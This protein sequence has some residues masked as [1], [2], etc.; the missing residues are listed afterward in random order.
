MMLDVAVTSWIADR[1]QATKEKGDKLNCIKIKH[2]CAS[3]DTLK[4]V[5]TTP[6]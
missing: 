5:K 6:R 3:K 2:F 1:K 4:I